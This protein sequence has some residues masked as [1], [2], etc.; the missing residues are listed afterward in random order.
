MTTPPNVPRPLP[1]LSRSPRPGP[2][3]LRLWSGPGLGLGLVLAGLLSQGAC[4][5][6]T[7]LA[8]GCRPWQAGD[9]STEP[10]THCMFFPG[11]VAIDPLGD[12]LYVA[13]T[14]ADL[15]FGGATL[16]SVDTLRHERAVE[17][18]RRLGNG[19]EMAGD[20]Q[21]GQV[22]CASSGHALGSS[23]TVEETE[24]TESI[25][26]QPPADFD[27]CY[28]E[29]DL[30]D[31]NVVNCEPQRFVLADQTVKLGF[32]P[33]EIQ[34]MA[35]DPAD[36]TQPMPEKLRRGLYLAVRGDPSVTL[37]DIERPL[38]LDRK[39]GTSPGVD[40]TCG[41]ERP[42]A[43][44]PG[45][46]YVLRSC[47]QDH[48]V[49]RTLDDLVIDPNDTNQDPRARFDVPTE[50]F[51]LFVDRGCI[52]PGFSH[53]RIQKQGD[54]FV[55][56]KGM[57]T[58]GTYYQYL[59][60]THVPSGQVSAYDLGKSAAKPQLP[61]LQDVS[62]PLFQADPTTG[63]RGSFAVAPRRR[64]DLSQPW[65]VSSR[66]SG[67]IS[68]FR[69]ASVGGPRIIPGSPLS[70]T[71]QFSTTL[72]DVRQLEFEPS[73]DR[74]FAT[75]YSPPALAIVNTRLRGAQGVPV[76]QVTGIVNLCPGP[77]RSLLRQ[78]P[79]DL[80]GGPVL[81]SSVYTACYLSGQ[82]AETDADSG[83]LTATITVGRGPLSMALNFGSSSVT[84]PVSG[85]VDPCTD[86]YVSD[87]EA[88]LRGVTCPAAAS[89]SMRL[90]PLGAGQPALGPR[91]YVSNYLDNTVSV[92]DLDPRSPS[93]RRMVSRIG[94]PSPKQVQ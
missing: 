78:V 42:P 52:E 29:R 76:N 64:G 60:V 13:N 75:L 48:R 57:D 73:G 14:N 94:L 90:R 1:L 8:P 33:G 70:L 17:C 82:I 63:L 11:S 26:G 36:W 81:A 54:P 10:P 59:T 28:C 9:G 53:T 19:P 35:E 40:V 65:Y 88:K 50:P 68:T 25:S 92:I 72:A 46:P 34:L 93:Y 89:G 21:C 23:A 74:L 84:T 6:R 32:F 20:A 38:L 27:R 86:P 80:M 66:F 47:A 3:R 87:D 67:Q 2:A 4:T 31:P 16:L 83:R 41:M 18:F 24:R 22:A 69:L 55:C 37:L 43:H 77:T 51:N 79:R 91:A 12:I 58:S 39:A 62:G 85:T 15:S 44:E 5:P 30:D 61:V 71:S 7:P 49:Q 56:Q 45:Q